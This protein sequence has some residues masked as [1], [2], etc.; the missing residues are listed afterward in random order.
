MAANV[1]TTDSLGKCYGMFGGCRLT[2]EVEVLLVIG[3]FDMD[4]P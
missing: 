3:G 4:R 1:S 2:A